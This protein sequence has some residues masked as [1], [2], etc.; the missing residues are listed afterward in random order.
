MSVELQTN[1]EVSIIPKSLSERDTAI[2]CMLAKDKALVKLQEKYISDMKAKNLELKKLQNKLSKK[3]SIDPIFVSTK[4][5]A[6]Y[7]DVDPSFLTKKQGSVFKLGV[8]FFKPA[9]Q[10][11]VR[12]DLEAL[13]EW[14]KSTNTLN[15]RDAKLDALLKRR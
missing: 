7:I 1:T 6:M 9:G 10:S 12:W 13:K 2:V 11:I 3:V 15:I 5:A 8:H 14:I 4:D